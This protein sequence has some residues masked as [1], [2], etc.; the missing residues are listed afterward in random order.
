MCIS[1]ICIYTNP[2]SMCTGL[3]L[4]YCRAFSQIL[5]GMV[6][7]SLGRINHELQFFILCDLKFLNFLNNKMG[8]LQNFF[9]LTLKILC[10]RLSKINLPLHK[11]RTPLSQKF[12][13]PNSQKFLLENIDKCS[14]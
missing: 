10:C 1:Y 7:I 6:V 13:Q 11:A 9:F 4:V 8:G 2:F 3:F 5:H 12:I 14:N